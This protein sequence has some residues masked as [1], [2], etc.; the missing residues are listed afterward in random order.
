MK[1]WRAMLWLLPLST[2]IP[3]S[4]F[5]YRLATTDFTAYFGGVALVGLVM[6]LGFPNLVILAGSVVGAVRAH[7]GRPLTAVVVCAVAC[8]WQLSGVFW[9]SEFWDAHERPGYLL[10]FA[11]PGAVAGLLG[12]QGWLLLRNV[13][14]TV[15]VITVVCL[16]LPV[17]SAAGATASYVD[18]VRR[19]C[20]PGPE[21]DL[22]FTGLENAHFT[23]SC[24]IPKG[25][26]TLAGCT[27]FHAAVGL[28]DMSGSWNLDFNNSA[29]SVTSD[30][31]PHSAPY[32][33]VGA[34]AAYG[35][36]FGWS[37]SYAF[38]PNSHCSGHV[39]ARLF[40]SNGPASGSVHVTGRFET[41]S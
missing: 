24:G 13:N 21:V 40:T 39:D 29:S 27:S 25:S 41:P 34:E 11:T 37:G 2:A 20:P 23:T 31:A 33:L 26:A 1:L 4:V 18:S 8:A 16:L 15:A 19:D 10:L 30:Q 35:G 38:D 6:L 14:R 28:Q 3:L 36:P 5:F 32:L 9:S 17:A 22:T 12:L 7:R